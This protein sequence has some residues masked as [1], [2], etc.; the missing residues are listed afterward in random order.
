[1]CDRVVEAEHVMSQDACVESIVK[2][3]L[4][5]TQRGVG[6]SACDEGDVKC[7]NLPTST[8]PPLST[9]DRH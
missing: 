9:T 5:C 3:H 7:V 6:S 4:V 1:M 8:P 2:L